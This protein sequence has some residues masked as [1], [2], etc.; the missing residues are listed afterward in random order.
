MPTW[1]YVGPNRMCA[2]G[3]SGALSR[4]ARYIFTVTRSY[5]VLYRFSASSLVILS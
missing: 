2:H 1:S 3:K 5:D 4:P